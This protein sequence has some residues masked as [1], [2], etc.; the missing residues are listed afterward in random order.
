MKKINVKARFHLGAACILIVFCASASILAYFYLKENVTENIYKETEIFIATADATRT[1]VKDMLRPTIV[2]LLPPE[3]FIPQAMS[4]SF[5]GREVMSRLHDRFPDFEYKRAAI[6]PMNPI[7]Q[8]DAFEL[9]M[10]TWF[11]ANKSKGEWHGLIQK[12]DRSFF[13]RL[14][15]IFAEAECLYCHGKPEDAPAEMKKIYGIT[16]GYH[17]EVGSAVAADTIY[18]PVDVSFNRIKEISWAVFLL[19][20]TSMFSLMFLFYL[21]FNR[22]IVL[23]LKGLLTKFQNISGIAGER[24][25][26]AIEMAGDETEQLKHA[27][28]TVAADLEMAHDHLLSSETKYRLLFE[29]SQDAILIFD[30]EERLSDINQAGIDLFRFIDL[31]EARAIEWVYQLFWDPQDAYPLIQTVQKKGYVRDLEIPMVD[32]YGKKMMVM[33]SAT[34]RYD[35]ANQYNGLN[36]VLHDI[37]QRRQIE[38]SMAQTE[39]LASIGQ[40]ASGVAHE[41]NNP[42][43][44]IRLHANLITKDTTI[45]EQARHDIGIIQKH[46]QNCRQIVE[47]LLNFA[48]VSKPE[49]LEI[50]IHACIEDVLAVLAIQL[51]E[52]DVTIIRQYGKHIPGVTVDAQQVRQVFMNILMNAKQAIREK[53]DI[54][55]QTQVAPTGRDLWIDI[56]DNGSGISEENRAK[57]FDPFYTSKSEKGGTG[58]GLSVSYGII[59]QH[60]GD[61]DVKSEVGRGSRFRIRLPLEE[62]STGT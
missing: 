39:K 37:T 16:G 59:Q 54:T 29:T 19:V 5:V 38:K 49:K 3:A 55:I 32:R 53:G 43:E 35:E 52:N 40:L 50:D 9:E 1:Y 58:L 41:I 36:A 56:S 23:E 62:G 44:I 7:N 42:L 60:G 33:I 21:L 27:F 15:P 46:T 61:I 18:I 8:A 2:G 14:R 4:T 34:A 31:A 6:N 13:T 45:S 51:Q 47:S 11:N 26:D 10:L 12:G 22:T 24:E 57:I 25:S 20:V 48:R 17:Y 30:K 28:E